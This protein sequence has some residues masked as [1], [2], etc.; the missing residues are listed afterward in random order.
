MVRVGYLV[1]LSWH[2]WMLCSEKHKAGEQD[3][4]P[5]TKLKCEIEHTQQPLNFLSCLALQVRKALAGAEGSVS[6]A[7]ERLT[8]KDAL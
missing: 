7:T 1:F 3:I 5:S 8:A 6:I 4:Y 2:D